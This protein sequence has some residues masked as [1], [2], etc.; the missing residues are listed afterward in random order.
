VKQA[1]IV[2]LVLIVLLTGLPLAMSMN[3][4]PLCPDCSSAGALTLFGMCAAII[5]LA[6]FAVA[7]LAAYIRPTSVLMRLL[8]LVRPL[9]KPPRGL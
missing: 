4:M 9:E 8:L 7:L 1:A 3:D 5:A 6:G 2:L